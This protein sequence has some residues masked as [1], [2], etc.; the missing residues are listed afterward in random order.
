MTTMPRLSLLT[1]NW[2]KKMNILLTQA[3]DSQH[4]YEE[5]ID[6][7]KKMYHNDPSNPLVRRFFNY[8]RQ[9]VWS[10]LEFEKVDGFS[11]SHLI[12]YVPKNIQDGDQMLDGLKANYHKFKKAFS[13]SENLFSLDK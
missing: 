8:I 3:V 2:I 10:D 1:E 6:E 9:K 5:A 12:D 11:S 4:A 13:E 7:L